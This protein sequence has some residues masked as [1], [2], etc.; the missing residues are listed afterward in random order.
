MTFF[1]IDP[2]DYTS[3]NIDGL[4]SADVVFELSR[5]GEKTEYYLP[6]KSVQVA[7]DEA[8]LQD[9]LDGAAESL[10]IGYAAGESADSVTQNV[11]LPYKAGSAKKFSVE[12]TSS[13]TERLFVS[14]YSWEDK[15][16]KV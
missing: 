6:N 1:F 12:W 16:G 14:G 2:N 5:D 8:K 11:T 4:R 9:L 13:D 7:W 3:Y 10:Q 15:T